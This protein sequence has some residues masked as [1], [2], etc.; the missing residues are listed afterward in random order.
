[1]ASGPLTRQQRWI[2]FAAS[3]AVGLAFLDEKPS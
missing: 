1:V 2:L 3:L